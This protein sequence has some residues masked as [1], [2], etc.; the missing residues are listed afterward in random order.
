MPGHASYLENARNAVVRCQARPKRP[1]GHSM[2]TIQGNLR[3]LWY[4]NMPTAVLKIAGGKPKVGVFTQLP[5]RSR[6]RLVFT[7]APARRCTRT[8]ALFKTVRGSDSK[9]LLSE[10]LC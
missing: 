1:Q 4:G 8:G 5:V 10:W 3:A 6:A 9:F 7:L 2:W